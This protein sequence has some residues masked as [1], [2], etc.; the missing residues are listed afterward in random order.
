M[1]FPMVPVASRHFLPL[2]LHHG[3]VL[4]RDFQ[5]PFGP[6]YDTVVLLRPFL[7]SER[8]YFPFYLY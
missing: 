6:D 7:P 5:A 3:L 1:L 4:H 2:P 8:V